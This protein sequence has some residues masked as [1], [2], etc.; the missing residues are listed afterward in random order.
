MNVETENLAGKLMKV[1]SVDEDSDLV[2]VRIVDGRT[3]SYTAHNY[4]LPAKGDILLVDEDGRPQQA[5][6]ALWQD[7]NS[8]AVVRHVD[9]DGSVLLDNGLNIVPATNALG[10]TL[11]ANNTVEYNE[12]D[13]VLRLISSTPIRSRDYGLDEAEI[14][15]EYLVKSGDEALTFEDFGGYPGVVSQ[16]RE[17]IDTQFK[18]R[19]NLDVIGAKPLKG[20]LLTGPPGTGKTHLARIIAQE[21]EADFFLISGPSV[22]S[23]W[24]GDTESTLRRLFQAATESSS[25]RAIIF[26]D[27]ID[28]LAERR[29]ATSHDYSNRL[30]AQLLTLLDGFDSGG[31]SVVVIAATNRIESLD[32]ALTRPG[33]FDWEI[34]FGTPDLHDRFDILRV[35][36]R[37]LKTDNDLPLADIAILSEGWSAAKL[38]ALWSEAAHIAARDRRFEIGGEDLALA[39]D[40]MAKRP[41]RTVSRE[42]A[43]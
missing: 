13:G 15:N 33:R 19:E 40:R 10:L 3:G 29:S 7:R 14:L 16:A 12:S 20:I 43:T 32:P 26:F 34:E 23:K 4:P 5:P 17:L 6:K 8:I 22:V 28:S 25:G 35:G 30:V 27:E 37:R 24:V 38:T 18:Y 11:E 39:H 31:K 41:D 2:Y 1:M 42:D 36:A 9:E 21:S